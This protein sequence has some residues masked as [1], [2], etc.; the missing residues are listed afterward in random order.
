MPLKFVIKEN[1]WL[2][3]STNDSIIAQYEEQ[4]STVLTIF[5]TKSLVI[6]TDINEPYK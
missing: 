2:I 6:I 3:I 1:T 4:F 5:S